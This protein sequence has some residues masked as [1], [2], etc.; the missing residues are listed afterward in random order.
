MLPLKPHTIVWLVAGANVPTISFNTPQSLT[1]QK[2]THALDSLVR[3][4]R[5][6]ERCLFTSHDS[7]QTE[8]GSATQ[9]ETDASLKETIKPNMSKLQL[10]HSHTQPA[11]FHAP[12]CML[13]HMRALTH[14]DSNTTITLPHLWD[15]LMQPQEQ[16]AIA[17]IYHGI[18]TSFA[19]ISAISSTFNPLFKVLFMFPSWYLFAIGFTLISSLGWKLPPTLRSNFKER[20]SWNASRIQRT[21]QLRQACHLP[22][23]PFPKHL[24]VH[25]CWDSIWRKQV[26]VIN[27]NFHTRLVPVH[28]PLLKNSHL[29]SD[30]PLT[31]ML[32]FSRLLC[33]MSCSYDVNSKMCATTSGTRLHTL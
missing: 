33:L 23:N 28:S 26:E 18:Q 25:L 4:S 12:D 13:Q 8:I 20:D 21:T 6:V 27:L 29:V 9:K 32:K 31:Y 3:V 5:R 30:P 16:Q 1:T 7:L 24:H 15:H 17:A 22:R 19:S 14:Q 10:K 2:L 11:S